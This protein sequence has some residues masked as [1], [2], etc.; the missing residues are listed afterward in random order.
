MTRS[1][2]L[3]DGLALGVPPAVWFVHL[4]AS[5]LLV[6][7]SCDAGHGWYLFTVTA[8]A[9]CLLFPAARRSLRARRAD[10]PRAIEAFLGASGVWLTALFAL[11]ILLVGL[12]AVTV[13]PCR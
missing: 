13:D 7:P 5:Y 4:N 12:A 10:D 2:T 9:L 6:P 11:A 8:V 1:S 3:A